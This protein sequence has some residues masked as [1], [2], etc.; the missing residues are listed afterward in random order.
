MPST[1]CRP[2]KTSVQ[3]R[4]T[5]GQ[6]RSIFSA[7]NTA[8]MLSAGRIRRVDQKQ[9]ADLIAAIDTLEK[10]SGVDQAEIDEW[11]LD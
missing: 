10:A 6:I 8:G 5:V 4:L 3:V 9:T 2:G 7:I 1:D 11:L